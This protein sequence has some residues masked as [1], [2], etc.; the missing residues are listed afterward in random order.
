MNLIMKMAF[1]LSIA[2]ILNLG[3][4]VYGVHTIES[5]HRHTS[6][7]NDYSKQESDESQESDDLMDKII[8]IGK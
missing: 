2:S 1:V 3:Q 6:E 5:T 7:A 4:P 8:I